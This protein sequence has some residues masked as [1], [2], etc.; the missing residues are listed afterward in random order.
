VNTIKFKF[1][2][3]F[4]LFIPTLILTSCGTSSSG[5]ALSKKEIDF[6][7]KASMN[8]STSTEFKRDENGF[9]TFDTINVL[10]LGFN[11]KFA[12][13]N[14]FNLPDSDFKDIVK[15]YALINVFENKVEERN[16]RNA[17]NAYCLGKYEID[18]SLRK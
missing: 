7:E 14:W 13:D 11:Q 4:L 12:T 9:T 15:Q 2:F 18:V 16:L 1:S 8:Q 6:C 5:D 17:I 3:A 10:S